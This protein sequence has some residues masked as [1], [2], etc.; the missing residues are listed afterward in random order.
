MQKICICQIKVVPLHQKSEKDV[1]TILRRKRNRQRWGATGKGYG[2][3]KHIP[4]AGG[5]KARS[6]TDFGLLAFRLPR[7]MKPTYI[8][9]WE[10]IF[11]LLR[12]LVRSLL[13]TKS[14][15][16]YVRRE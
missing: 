12:T 5:R 13:C 6:L 11:D 9:L 2:G 7:D 14:N 15:R 3:V 16:D 4:P 8:L 10:I 1:M